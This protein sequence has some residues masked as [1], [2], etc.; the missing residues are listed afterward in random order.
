MKY[1]SILYHLRMKGSL[2]G[3]IGKRSHEETEGFDEEENSRVH[4][5][6]R[7]GES[8][9]QSMLTDCNLTGS[10]FISKINH[11][12][13]CFIPS[14]RNYFGGIQVKMVLCDTGCSTI[15]LPLEED[16]ITD[17]FLKF[18][19]DDFI[20]S[21]ARSSNAAGVSS[22]LRIKHKDTPNFELKLCQD[23][24]SN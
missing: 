17:I 5:R 8:E 19:M 18:C 16:Q 10:I 3:P 6:P 23:L 14:T 15:L 1:Q 12:N 13:R 7:A 9:P 21:V 11:K 22:F 24:V 2:D 4:S 20:I